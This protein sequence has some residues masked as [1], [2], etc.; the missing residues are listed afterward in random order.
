MALGAA[1]MSLSGMPLIL[2]A[3]GVALS[4]VW[5]VGDALLLWP[6]SV[7]RFELEDN[8]SGRWFDRRGRE[9]RI[10]S[11]RTTWVSADL[12]VL[13]MQGSR[14]RTRWL[15]LLPDSAAKEAMR[16]LRAWLRWRPS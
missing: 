9:H 14:W 16:R 15:V 1:W 2:S 6:S 5:T 13:G 10:N 11:T 8:G 7:I 3:T 12:V 4:G